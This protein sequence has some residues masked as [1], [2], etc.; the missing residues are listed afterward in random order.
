M[1][2]GYK[3]IDE[4]ILFLINVKG[5]FYCKYIGRPISTLNSDWSLSIL[6]RFKQFLY[7]QLCWNHSITK[8]CKPVKKEHLKSNQIAQNVRT[9]TLN[10]WLKVADFSVRFIMTWYNISLLVV[11]TSHLYRKWHVSSVPMFLCHSKKMADKWWEC[12]VNMW[13]TIYKTSP[14]TQTDTCWSR[15]QSSEWL[16][17]HP[18][19]NDI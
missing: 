9:K 2:K 7:N 11:Y 5:F 18:F 13:I 8:K 14:K 17:V 19:T 3:T 10:M 15:A 12:R 4:E 1:F 16:V 6:C